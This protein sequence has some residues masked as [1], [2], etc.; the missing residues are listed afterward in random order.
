MSNRPF[1]WRCGGMVT[2]RLRRG[3]FTGLASCCRDYSVAA[4]RGATISSRSPTKEGKAM[5]THRIATREQWRAERLAVLEA[6]N[7]LTHRSDEL[8]RRREL[9]WVKIDIHVRPRLQRRLHL[10][11]GDRQRLQRLRG[12]NP[13]TGGAIT[14]NTK[15]PNPPRA[16][17]GEGGRSAGYRTMVSGSGNGGRSTRHAR[18]QRT[19]EVSCRPG[20]S[21]HRC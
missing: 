6:E 18:S 17:V 10:L 2:V 8:A 3:D 12:A 19:G 13:F 16:Y 20:A 15:T 4:R 1:P 9:P 7:D 21:T 14:T 11:L 5:S